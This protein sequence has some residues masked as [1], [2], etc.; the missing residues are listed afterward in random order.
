[1]ANDEWYY[2]RGNQQQGPV[3]LAAL[4]ELIRGGQLQPNDLVWR[5]G[6]GSWQSASQVP[7]VYA[8]IAPAA[9]AAAA[10]PA[11]PPP[12]APA[13]AYAPPGGQQQ[14]APQPGY[15]AQPQAVYPPGTVPNHLV[16][17]ILS[18][19]CCQPFGIVAII[20]AAQV[21]SKLAMGDYQGALD[22]SN[23]AKTWALVALGCWVFVAFA[24]V[25]LMVVG[26]I[27]GQ[28]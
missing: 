27:A 3:A 15:Y 21:N 13:A 1:M 5:N 4:Q 28:H 6:M 24:W 17:A 26:A 12:Q 23:K 9:P 14:Y 16:W 18:I 8:G 7:E 10:P 11:Y 2:A 22:S 19:F 25:G 20:F